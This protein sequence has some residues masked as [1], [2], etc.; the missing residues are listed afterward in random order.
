MLRGTFAALVFLVFFAGCGHNIG[1]SCQTNVE[2]DPTGLRFCDTAPV[3]GYCTIDGCDVN[4]CPSEAVCIRFFTPVP[5]EPC[6]APPARF[7]G[8]GCRVDERCV[9]NTALDD[10]GNCTAPPDENGNNGLC[11]PE[12]SERR[13][14]QKRCNEDSDCR[15]GYRCRPTGELGAELVPSPDGGTMSAKFCA[16]NP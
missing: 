6:Q 15:D 12:T 4:T 16:P 5:N 14:C 2:C 8:N 10:A 9:C 13:W 3:G 1:D 7:P 11:S